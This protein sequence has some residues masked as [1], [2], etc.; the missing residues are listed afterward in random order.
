MNDGTVD[1]GA[2]PFQVLRIHEMSEVDLVGKAVVRNNVYPG[3][4]KVLR[5]APE[6]VAQT[7][8]LSLS[9]GGDRD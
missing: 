4:K 2:R 1:A 6:S 8:N 3:A 9:H 5:G 7:K